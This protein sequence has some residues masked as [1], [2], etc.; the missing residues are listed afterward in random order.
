MMYLGE[1]K[2]EEVGDR[3]RRAR[4]LLETQQMGP[5][6]EEVNGDV[7]KLGWQHH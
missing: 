7:H 2:W 4:S 6:F 1:S 3:I 5:R